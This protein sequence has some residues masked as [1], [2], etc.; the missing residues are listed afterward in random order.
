MQ[1][2]TL[3]VQ[4]REL[5]SRGKLNGMRRG[6]WI[7]AV[8]YGAIRGAASKNK[9]SK[10]VLLQVH[11]KSFL[12]MVGPEQRSN[13][14][15]ELKWG[16]ESANVVIKEI[17]RDVVSRHLLHIDFQK[18]LMTEKLEVMVPIHVIG[19]APGVKLSG[20]ILEHITRELKIL[21]LP[22]DIPQQIPVD[23]SHLEIGQG[24]SVKDIKEISG[25]Q[26]LA[27]PHLLIVN[28]VAPTALEE[29]PAV[30][31]PA[32]TEPEV[33]AKGKKPEEGEAAAAS[34]PAKTPEKAAGTPSKETP[35]S[36]K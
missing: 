25:V 30:A 24:L 27:D 4:E 13:A 36:N 16:Q 33:I 12:K 31:A 10:N 5:L 7:P 26:I 8:L 14:I 28:V 1:T 9:K 22:K 32:T 18:I 15:L 20:G 11:E 34:T 21:S 35:K 6:G 29:A 2:I 17:Q 19:E 23:V 3:D